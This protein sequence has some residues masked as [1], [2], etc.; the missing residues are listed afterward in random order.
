[1]TITKTVRF[2]VSY[3]QE[4]QKGEKT[5]TFQEFCREAWDCQREVRNAMNAASS[6]YKVQ[7]ERELAF[8]NENGIWPTKEEKKNGFYTDENGRPIS[9]ETV[10]D[11]VAKKYVFKLGTDHVYGTI[12]SELPKWNKS[13]KDFISGQRAY[14]QFKSNQPI[15]IKKGTYEFERIA[16]DVITVSFSIFSDSYRKYLGLKSGIFTFRC[17]PSI[18]DK[19]TKA[20]L[21]KIMDGTYQS[22]AGKLSYDSR[23]KKWMFSCTYTVEKADGV[24]LDQ[25][26]ILGVDLGF[27]TVAYCAV[28][29]SPERF[30]ISGE[31]VKKFRDKVMK[32][33]ISMLKTLPY[34]QGGK[35]GHGTKCRVEKVYDAE[36][37]IA[38]FRETENKN[39]AAAIVDFAVKNQCGVIQL[40][41]LSGV[42]DTAPDA[43]AKKK[44]KAKGNGKKK[45]TDEAQIAMIGMEPS[46]SSDNEKK[47]RKEENRMLGR[48]TFYDLKQRIEMKAKEYGIVV[49]VVNPAYTSQRCSCCGY[50][51][52]ESRPET[53][54][55]HKWFTCVKCGKRLDADYNAAVN[56]SIAGIEEIIK[57]QLA[58]QKV[59]EEKLKNLS[60]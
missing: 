30:F 3:I 34:Q 42:R 18:K 28:S 14:P 4:M 53:G 47:E 33:R 16:Q 41:N 46:E 36:D 60:E 6:E 50:I 48:W 35:V 32:R 25:N 8:F 5:L 7:I 22:A 56:L 9:L 29:N 38:R 52:S 17:D 12:N 26:K 1:M 13:K 2:P 24:Q 10:L 27:N 51:S 44:K 57:E 43:N 59:V 39:Y 49:S 54:E 55:G 15:L 23:N 58:G 21:H 11:H 20:I 31:K 40:E 19:G 37:K 45:S